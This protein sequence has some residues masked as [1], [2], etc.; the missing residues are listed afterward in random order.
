MKINWRYIW[1]DE[2]WDYACVFFNEDGSIAA[3]V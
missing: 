1:V 2:I 3:I